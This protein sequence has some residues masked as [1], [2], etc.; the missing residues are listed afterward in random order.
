VLCCPGGSTVNVDQYNPMPDPVGFPSD[1]AVKW[2]FAHVIDSYSFLDEWQP[3]V[4]HDHTLTG[5]LVSQRYNMPVVTTNHSTFGWEYD[6]YYRFISEEVPIVA[7]SQHQASTTDIPLAGVV[8]NGT[9][10][11]DIP[12]GDGD[13]EYILWIG[14]FDD[15]KGAY[16]AIK[17]AHLC[18]IPLRLAA[19]T[20]S[21]QQAAYFHEKVETYLGDLGV[22][23][24]GEVTGDAKHELIGQAVCLLNP[25]KWDEP[26]GMVMTEALA[27]G[28]PVVA[29]RRGA[30]TEIVRHGETGYLGDS[31]S[32]LCDG[33]NLCRN[34]TL[35]RTACR[36]DALTRFSTG[37]MVEGYLE[38]YEDVMKGN[39]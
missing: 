39:W 22:E 29:M 15:A 30:A 7:I 23:Y 17:V 20:P 28:T 14:R 10:V 6:L 2:E 27:H 31:L 25:I 26:F 11:E 3:D 18:D 5:P 8:Y 16:E 34:F 32:E 9:D 37:R 13:G 33:V 21:P 35:S 36:S 19:R 1:R 38:I 12:S 4:I 24:V